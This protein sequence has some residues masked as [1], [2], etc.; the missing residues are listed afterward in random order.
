[1]QG[2]R[3]W[4]AQDKGGKEKCQAHHDQNGQM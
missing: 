4:A 3:P 2:H 1:M